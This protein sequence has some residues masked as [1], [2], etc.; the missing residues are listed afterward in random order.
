MY[1]SNKCEKVLITITS[2][3]AIPPKRGC[4]SEREQGYGWERLK[5]RERRVT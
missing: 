3:I 4:E 5:R 1:A 2:T